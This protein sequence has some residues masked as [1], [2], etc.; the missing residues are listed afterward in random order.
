MCVDLGLILPP[1]VILVFLSAFG[2]T[3]ITWQARSESEKGCD[4]TAHSERIYKDFEMY[5]KVML[6]IVGAVG[7]VRL[8]KFD[9]P[10]AARQGMQY[11]GALSLFV[12]TIFCIFILCH[13]GSKVRRWKN[14]EWPKAVFW[15]ELWA[16]IAM[17]LFSSSIWWLVN[18]W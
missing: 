13:Q 5:L 7:Y 15:Q 11:L 16:C 4:T 1:V 14:I 8:T 18:V 9:D 10:E 3:L 17:W 6:A 2:I 12:M